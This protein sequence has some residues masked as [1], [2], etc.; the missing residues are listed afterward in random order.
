MVTGGPNLL[1]ITRALVGFEPPS[2]W[3]GGGGL[4]VLEKR[5][6]AIES[7]ARTQSKL[8][9]LFVAST[10]AAKE[11]GQRGD[12]QP[13]SPPNFPTKGTSRFGRETCKMGVTVYSL[14]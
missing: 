1:S 5:E 10:G 8:F 7:S 3:V 11:C 14:I 9:R 6:K 12:I 13:E 4:R 2:P